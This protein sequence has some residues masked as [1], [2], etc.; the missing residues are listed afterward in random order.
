MFDG[1]IYGLITGEYSAGCGRKII[2]LKKKT[3]I[4][5]LYIRGGTV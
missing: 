3:S 1:L 4:F 2:F 5:T